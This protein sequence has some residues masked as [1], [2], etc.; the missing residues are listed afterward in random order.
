MP[1]TQLT[2]EELL[3]TLK[4]SSIPTVLVEGENDIIFYRRIEDD[5]S[6]T[7][8]SMLPAGNKHAVLNIKKKIEIS[9]T[10]FKIPIAYIVDQDTW[11]NFGIPSNIENI[12]TTRG[13]SIEND[14][15]EDGEIYDLLT[16]NEKVNF[17][18]EKEKFIY[19]Y[20]LTLNRNINNSIKSDGSSYVYQLHPGKV[21]DDE[22]FFQTETSLKANEDYPQTLHDDISDN[23]ILKLRGKSLLSLLVR[24][25]SRKKRKVKYSLEVLMDIS[26]SKKGSNYQ[27]IVNQLKE[28]LSL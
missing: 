16:Q 8:L 3:A 13:Y 19:W 22:I 26:A 6:E 1:K 23:W 14:L 11:I 9:P 17:N 7:G 18:Q 4:H 28:K 12:I 10:E 25:L 5:F 2:E 20:S 21:L 27:R 15:F 24:Q